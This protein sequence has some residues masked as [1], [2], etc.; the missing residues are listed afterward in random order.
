MKSYSKYKSIIALTVFCVITGLFIACEKDANTIPGG[1]KAIVE[2]YLIPNQPITLKVKKEIAYNE[3]LTNKE[4][5]LMGLSIK[6]TGD[7]QTYLLKSFQDTLYKSDDNVRLK[8]GVT[9]NLSFDYNGKTVSASTII[10]TK[11]TG[12]ASDVKSIV[13]T[14]QVITTTGGFGRNLDENVDVNLS[15][16]N[17]TNDYHFVVADNIEPKPDLIVTLPTT[18]STTVTEFNRRFRSQPV[19]GTAT[20]LRS[21]QFQYFGKYN[22]VLLK[23]NPDYAALYNTSGTTS[24]NIS[25]PPTTITNGLGVFTGVNAD[26]LSFLVRER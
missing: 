23:V 9:Y 24:Q 20:R 16:T 7:G 15:W 14:R 3:D 11:P 25:T 18:S 19:Q 1:A 17:P 4:T 5:F 2:A 6:I 10:P 8:V 12:L 26:T 21:Q 13:R 22:I